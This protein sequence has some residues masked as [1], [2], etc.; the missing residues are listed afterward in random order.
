MT[1]VSIFEKKG[2]NGFRRSIALIIE[3]LYCGSRETFD[4]I[5]KIAR[6]HTLQTDLN[7][8]NT[9][10]LTSYNIVDTKNNIS[11]KQNVKRSQ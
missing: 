7:S 4:N 9:I 2:R 1:G 10:T 11:S 5:N 6:D 3:K 8:I